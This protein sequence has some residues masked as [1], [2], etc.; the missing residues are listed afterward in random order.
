MITNKFEYKELKRTTTEKQRLY[1]CPDGNAVPSVTTIL[2]KTKSAESKA[3]LARWRKSVGEA[4]AQAIVTEA[5]N[6][7]TRMHTYLEKYVLGEELKETV[8]NPYAQQSL[9]MA[10]IVV[11]EGL[12]NVDEYWGTEVALYFPK[13]YAGTTDLVGVHKGEAAILDFKQTNK[14]K[15]REWIEDYFMQLVAYA[16]A[17]NEVYGTDIRKG[18]VLMCS[19]DYAYQ[20]FIAEGD[21]WDMWKEKWWAR[22]EQYYKEHR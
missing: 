1:T 13:I 17:H 16:E 5:A 8:S 3:G 14:P 6:R 2:D 22:V 7:G 9:D 11:E 4:K 10:K 19:K 18:V 15:K 21:E 12:C 20:E